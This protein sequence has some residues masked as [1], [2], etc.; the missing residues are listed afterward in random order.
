VLLE[1]LGRELLKHS[2]MAVYHFKNAK[3][4]D[5]FEPQDWSALVARAE[6]EPDRRFVLLVDEVQDNFKAPAWSILL[7]ETS[8]LQNFVV[9]GFGI[10]QLVE[11]S[12]VLFQDMWA[13]SNIYL[14]SGLIVTF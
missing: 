9:V 8:G 11:D 5:R 1:L 3:D 4:L 12:P 2:Q 14:T 6:R 10:K 7:R 13:A